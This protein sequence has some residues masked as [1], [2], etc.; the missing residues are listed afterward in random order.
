VRKEA[1]ELFEKDPGLKKPEHKPLL[2]ELRR[3][4]K[5]EGDELS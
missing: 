5:I 1:I 2:K 4:W 3:V